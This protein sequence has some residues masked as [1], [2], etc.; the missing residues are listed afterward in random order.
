MCK[1]EVYFYRG[2]VKH[3]LGDVGDWMGMTGWRLCVWWA[4]LERP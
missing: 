2:M 3:E 4:G 1:Q